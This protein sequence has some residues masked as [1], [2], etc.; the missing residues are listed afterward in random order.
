MTTTPSIHGLR[1]LQQQQEGD[2]DQ[3]DGIVALTIM[4]LFIFCVAWCVY[5][6]ESSSILSLV[7]TVQGLCAHALR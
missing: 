4:M 2:S 3:I 6:V 5:L 7:Y 1:L